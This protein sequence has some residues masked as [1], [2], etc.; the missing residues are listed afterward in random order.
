[1][2]F[3]EGVNYLKM[4]VCSVCGGATASKYGV[5]TTTPSCRREYNRLSARQYYL[6]NADKHKERVRRYNMCRSR[7]W[8]GLSEDERLDVL[9]E[10]ICEYYEKQE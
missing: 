2:A 6:R 8:C 9:E 5:C 7:V 10:Y 1:M 4:G 3:C